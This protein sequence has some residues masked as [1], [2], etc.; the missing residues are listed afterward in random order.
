MLRF[1]NGTFVIIVLCSIILTH[2]IIYWVN[3]KCVDRIS[4]NDSYESVKIK[5]D[6]FY[7]DIVT[8]IKRA[9]NTCI[10]LRTS[11]TSN[12]NIPGWNTHVREKHDAAREAFSSMDR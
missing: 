12:H 5:L 3:I 6:S 2:L 7:C 9:I 1:N 11:N 4:G 10:P 8:C